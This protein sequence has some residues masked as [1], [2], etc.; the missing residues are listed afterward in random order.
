MKPFYRVF[1]QALLWLAIWVM[2]GIGQPSFVHFIMDNFI[3]FGFQVLL[4]SAIVYL[5][6]PKLLFT[7]KIILFVLISLVLLFLLP[8]L[9][10]ELI[11]NGK[12]GRPPLNGRPKPPSAFMIHFLFL[13]IAYVTATFIETIFYAR[14]KEADLLLSKSENLE[15]E[16]KLLKSQINPHFLFNSLNNIY[17]L[18]TI[19]ASK[20]QQSISYLSDML[21]YVIYDCEKP[22][23]P[24]QKEVKYI[25]DYIQLFKIKSS[26]NY[27]ITTQFS[28]E[29][30][31]LRIT[32][33]LLIPFVEN[34]FKHGTIESVE[35]AFITL[36]LRTKAY[37]VYFRIE[38]SKNSNTQQKDSQGGIGIKNVKKRLAILYPNNHSLQINETRNTFRVELKIIQD[39]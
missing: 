38:N 31:H 23:V 10:T 4:I 25:Q 37:E 39:A 32:P 16:L 17:S 24:I 21:R 12:F 15:T 7:K 28:I 35:K 20:T 2:M 26:K 22:L 1:Y 27:P 33:M 5:M 29:N 19:D 14:K 18:S 34:A 11:S 13:G 6:A 9:S 30:Q 3:T 8:K 36:E